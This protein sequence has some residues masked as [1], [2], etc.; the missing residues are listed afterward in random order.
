L[1]NRGGEFLDSD[2]AWDCYGGWLIA[3]GRS[4]HEAVMREFRVALT[5]IPAPDDVWE[6][7]MRSCPELDQCQRVA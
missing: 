4:F 7:G 2:D 1:L 3:Q 6:G 5:R